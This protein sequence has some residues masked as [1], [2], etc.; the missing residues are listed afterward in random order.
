MGT[1]GIDIR[2]FDESLRGEI[3]RRRLSQRAAAKSADVSESLLS[4]ILSGDT[5]RVTPATF[6][7]LVGVL[8]EDPA[9]LLRARGQLWLTDA[10]S[11]RAAGE[12]GGSSP[13]EDEPPRPAVDPD[14]PDATGTV[15]K[16]PP[17][18][19]SCLVI[20]PF[21]DVRPREEL[22]FPSFVIV[23]RQGLSS[24]AYEV[25]GAH[26]LRG[27]GSI[28][29]QLEVALQSADLVVADLTTANPNVMFELGIRRATGLPII[30]IAE[31]GTKLPF[32]VQSE[33]VLFL[34]PGLEGAATLLQEL[35]LRAPKG[36]P[37][38]PRRPVARFSPKDGKK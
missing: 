11:A 21:R 29:E 33:R 17:G 25:I 2:P 26:E 31:Q 27:N 7:R 24:L 9:E 19:R 5:T 14:R 22:R 10:R 37:R 12:E 3:R 34:K 32:D 15:Q 20:G 30:L 35:P 16:S 1:R 18:M 23:V 36:P 6:G 4:K 38:S 28:P 8:G 13:E